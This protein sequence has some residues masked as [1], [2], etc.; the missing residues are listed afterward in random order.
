MEKFLQSEPLGGKQCCQS[1]KEPLNPWSKFVVPLRV[2]GGPG[3]TVEDIARKCILNRSISFGIGSVGS[4]ETS[5]GE[6]SPLSSTSDIVDPLSFLKSPPASY[7]LTP[8][9]SPEN[10]TYIKEKIKSAYC[11][12]S[13]LNFTGKP[14][15][16][17]TVQVARKDIKT[18]NKVTHKT[19][20]SNS[21]VKSKP[22]VPVPVSL[23][24]SKK[25]VHKCTYPNCRKVYTK[26]SHLK[27]HQRTHTGGSNVT[28]SQLVTLEC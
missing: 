5:S 17:F 18:E 22:K 14:R 28:L 26:S 19:K 21:T 6:I 20:H 7:V 10:K 4:L 25:R 2:K 12:P 15:N 16:T 24:S 23:D 13:N 9:A 27:A 3:L 11:I 1:G 8:P